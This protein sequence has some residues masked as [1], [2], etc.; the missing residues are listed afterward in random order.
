MD[1][2]P[3]A[4]IGVVIGIYAVIIVVFVLYLRTLQNTLKAVKPENRTV[5]P[6]NVWLMFIPLFNFV[7]QFI[8]VK[9]ISTS[10]KAEYDSRDMYPGED[11]PGYNLGLTMSVLTL[12]GW[13]PFIGSLL[14]IGQLVVWIMYWIKM[15]NYK[16]EM[17]GFTT[18]ET[19][20][21]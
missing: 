13:I 7:Y 1:Q 21:G 6:G 17:S 3:S 5:E 9:R 15:N 16:N 14:S 20:L 10:I 4:L 8:L 18:D 2:I 12:T 19:I 11:K